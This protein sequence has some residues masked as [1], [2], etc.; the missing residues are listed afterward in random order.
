MSRRDTYFDAMLRH[1]GVSYYQTLRGEASV[2]D[3]ARAVEAVAEFQAQGG[4]GARADHGGP[5]SA[6]ERGAVHRL[7]GQWR[8]RDVMTTNVATA[9]RNMPYK[10][11]AKL[12]TDQQVTA[13][14]VVSESGRV[15]GVVSEADL[16]RKVEP[17]P[18]GGAGLSGRARRDRAKARAR[19]AGELM[20]SPAI[21]IHPD[22][23]LSAAARL[24]NAHH[25]RRL[26]VVDAAGGL[27]GI[28]SRR[29][30]MKVFLRPDEEITAEVSDVL[31]QILLDDA[32]QVVVSVL[33]G[34]VTLRGALDGEDLIRVAAGLASQ[35]AGVVS[36]A[37]MLTNAGAQ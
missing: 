1:L 22:A 20:T 31:G 26:P 21:T 36:V 37:N 34:V 35:V 11:A 6:P 23:S 17:R 13:V 25:I 27:I 28:V 3:V 19:I 32:G 33:D 14:P 9:G 10:Q 8:V 29:D 2:E 24:M 7:R 16:L 4:H 18:R 12:M 15:I 5:D 30:L